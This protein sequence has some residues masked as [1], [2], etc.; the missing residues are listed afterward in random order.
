MLDAADPLLTEDTVAQ[1]PIY[2][3]IA[4]ST[5]NTTFAI[6][7]NDESGQ[8]YAW[9]WTIVS[10]STDPTRAEGEAVTDIPAD[11]SI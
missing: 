7:S 8:P 1:Y 3:L 11:L 5:I 10:Q 2:S 4:D 6:G 9:I